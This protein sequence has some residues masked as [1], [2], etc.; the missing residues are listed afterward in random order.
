MYWIDKPMTEQTW[1]E[2]LLGCIVIFVVLFLIWLI[3][4]IVYRLENKR[5]G[6]R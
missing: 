5:G 2:E 4:E 3:G 6:K 1:Q